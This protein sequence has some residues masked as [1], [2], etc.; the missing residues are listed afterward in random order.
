MR[1]LDN[2]LIQRERRCDK[3][4]RDLLLV[5]SQK[6][7]GALVSTTWQRTAGTNLSET[8]YVGGIVTRV[9]GK[10]HGSARTRF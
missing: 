10:H 6:W 5:R 4:G 9:H 7:C 1:T 3:S 8:T 2:E